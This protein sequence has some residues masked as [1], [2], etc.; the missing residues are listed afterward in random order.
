M[1]IFECLNLESEKWALVTG[2]LLCAGAAAFPF[3]VAATNIALGIALISGMVSGQ[4]LKGAKLF[5]HGHR[6][7]A[8]SMLFYWGLL[9][10]GLV[11]S[12]D[13]DW[14]LHVLG[15]QWFWLLVPL[16]VTALAS[17]IWRNRFL[18]ALSLG[19]TLHLGFC[20]LQMLGYVN[21]TTTASTTLNATG[22]IG[23]IGFGVVY[24]IWAGWLLHWGWEQPGLRRQVAWAL[25]LW[26]WA[27]IFAAQGRSGYL[28]AV[29]VIFVVLWKHLLSGHSWQ[30]AC[31]T[32]GLFLGVIGMLIA[33]PGKERAQET[34]HSF[35]AFQ[36]GG[37]AH[38]EP[39]WSL[40]FSAIETWKSH[41][42]LGVGTGGFPKAADQ[43]KKQWPEFNYDDLVELRDLEKYGPLGTV[44][45]MK[46]VHP[47][48]MYL[49]SLA[50]W[51]IA[52]VVALGLLLVL[53]ICTGWRLDWSKLQA[54]PLITLSGVALA[55]HGLSS[56]SLEEHFSSILAALLLGVGL[57][58][59]INKPVSDHVRVA[60][61]SPIPPVEAPS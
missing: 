34:W 10:L 58:E 37:L 50:R 61:S 38:A 53:W 24:G 39:R 14:G 28:V 3:S 7:L 46:T 29:T 47:H 8:A 1:K 41:P 21:V 40:W 25:S 51:G 5:W 54:G 12:N 36:Q 13:V 31:I 18:G 27:M 9:A 22:H 42:V 16:A 44:L 4:M 57:A 17:D 48:N 60:E 49:F 55:V 45:R 26:A 56:A 2:W 6:W 20:L 15:R 11:W 30:R 35:K 32:V 59:M 43:V 23:H 52:G 19:L 33:G